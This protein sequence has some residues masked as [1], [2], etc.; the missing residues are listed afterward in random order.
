MVL[1]L[2]RGLTSTY[3]VEASTASGLL[4]AVTSAED[5]DDLHLYIGGSPVSVEDG[6][7]DKL[8]PGTAVDVSASLKGGKVHGSLARAGKVRGQVRKESCTM[9]FQLDP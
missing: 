5:T 1:L 8:V 4:D 6:D 3:T 7:L 9:E 2:I